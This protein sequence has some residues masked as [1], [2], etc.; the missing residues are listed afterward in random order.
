MKYTTTALPHVP[1]YD[2]D[3]D[4]YPRWT[5]ETPFKGTVTI[6]L[7]NANEGQAVFEDLTINRI[8]VKGRIGFCRNHGHIGYS[9]QFGMN[10][11]RKGVPFSYNDAPDGAKS[12][13]REYVF[14]RATEL[15]S[16]P[17]TVMLAH[18]CDVKR[19][20]T[21]LI[22]KQREAQKAAQTYG[23]RVEEMEMM[24]RKNEPFCR[25][26]ARNGTSRT[27]RRRTQHDGPCDFGR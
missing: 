21:N 15:L 6:T 7:Y 4:D 10:V 1:N 8:N 25:E 19:E 11:G 14:A 2:V 20:I 3:G 27:C 24:L 18:Q 12:K 22:G 13:I 23:E 5:Y 17:S 9:S 16:D 26:E